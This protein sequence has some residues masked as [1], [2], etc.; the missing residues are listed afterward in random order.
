MTTVITDDELFVYAERAK[1]KVVVLTGGASGI[2][3]EVALTFSKHGAKVVIGDLDAAG[4]EAVV[5]GIIKNGGEAASVKC[6]VV[7]WDDQLAL[8]DLAFERYGAVDIVIPNA[9]IAEVEIGVGSG[10]LTVVDGKPIAPKLATLEVNLIGVFYTVHLGMHYVKRNRAPDSWKAIVLIGSIASWMG[11]IRDHSI[12][13]QS[14]AFGTDACAVFLRREGKHPL[15]CHSPLVR[16]YVDPRAPNQVDS[17]RYPVDAVPRIAGAIFL[18][19]TDPDPATSGCPWVLP[20]DGPVIRLEKE[21]LRNGVYK[22][23]DERIR[24]TTSFVTAVRDWIRLY[25]DLGRIFRPV[26]MAA[27]PVIVLAVAL[28]WSFAL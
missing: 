25:R 26:L 9:G 12:Q 21:S 17:R 19:A 4:A 20:D 27:V 6:N 22:M 8:F 5:A 14:M 3:K 24:R 15:G 11:L 23:M 10:H 18:T 1:G 2:G 7:N 16:G 28:A 13:P